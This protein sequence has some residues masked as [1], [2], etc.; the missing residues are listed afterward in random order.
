MGRVPIV[1]EPPEPGPVG[2]DGQTHQ[3][4]PLANVLSGEIGAKADLSAR[5]REQSKADR[6]AQRL[7]PPVKD[8]ALWLVL[9]PVLLG[10]VII[11]SALVALMSMVG[12]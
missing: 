8:R 2:R 10:A 4:N 6:A 5:H 7:Q 3:S 12:R 9:G 1:K 11:L